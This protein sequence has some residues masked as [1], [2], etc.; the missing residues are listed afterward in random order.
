[1]TLALLKVNR[2]IQSVNSATRS[3]FLIKMLK[4]RSTAIF[5]NRITNLAV[6][7]AQD[8]SEIQKSRGAL[9]VTNQR[10]YVW[11][12]ISRRFSQAK[13]I[14]IRADKHYSPKV[15]RA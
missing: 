6:I 5:V 4:L 1:V 11:S 13:F 14:V 7:N 12:A 10:W 2:R 9:T 8:H 15:I 3:L